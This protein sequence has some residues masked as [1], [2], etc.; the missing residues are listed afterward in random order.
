[1]VTRKKYLWQ[2]PDG[3]WYVRRHGRYHRISAAEGTAEFDRQYWDILNGR[4]VDEKTSWKALIK[5]YKSSTRWTDLKPRTRADYEKV[6]A[7][8]EEKAGTRSVKS[9]TRAD[10]INSQMANQHR[11]RFA[12]YIPQ[13]FVILCEH[14]KDLGW[15][16]ENPA[17]GVRALKVPKERKQEHLPWPDAA[18]NKFRAEAHDFE[19]LIFEI[20]VGTAQRP[21]DWTKFTW[22]DYDGETL[23]I[24]QGKTDVFLVLPCTR[25]L[26]AE[27]DR[28]KA[29]LGFIPIASRPILIKKDGNPISYRY[30]ADIMLKERRRLGLGDFDLHALRYRAIKELAWAGCS[31]EEIAAYSGHATL[32]MI[33]KYAGEARQEMRARQAAEKR[34]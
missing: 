15:L 11:T 5:S 21:A 10:V 4:R 27:L 1:M 26:K 8:I 31:D 33:R 6:L 14:A 16:K 7:Y 24:K 22:G 34:R 2:H 13:I 12:N 23:K 30:M 28:E 17:N 25:F 32:A 19:R 9:L 20:A 3:G 18:V 29:S